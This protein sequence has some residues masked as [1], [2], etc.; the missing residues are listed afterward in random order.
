MKMWLTLTHNTE[1]I[2]F[3]NI[4]EHDIEW[5]YKNATNKERKCVAEKYCV[6]VPLHPVLPSWCDVQTLPFIHESHRID[7]EIFSV[8]KFNLTLV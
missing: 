6:D 1:P 7:R 3:K 4:R 5:I 2:A 8:T